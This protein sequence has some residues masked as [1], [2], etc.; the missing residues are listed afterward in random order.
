VS[1][2]RDPAAPSGAVELVLLA[3]PRGF[4]AGVE[5]AIKALA[6]M[7]RAFDA[8][9]YC[10]HEIVHNKLVV[11]RFEAQGVVFVNDISEVPLGRPIMLS[12]HGSAP[13][14]VA[15]ARARGSY[16]VDSVCPL[17]TKVHHEVKVRA[18]KGYR[19]VYVGH[20]GHEEAMGTMAVAPDAI[21]RVESVAE[22]EALPDF[23][24]PTALLAQT[25]LSHRDW[26]GVADAVR[27]RYPEVWSPGRS[28]LCF[29]TT[30][31]QS[32]L[33]AMAAR[34]D[35]IVVIGSANSSNTRALEKLAIEAGCSRVYRVNDAAE[36]PADLAGTVGV[37]AGAS[38]PEELVDAVIAR[39]APARG[40]ELVNVTDEDEYFPPP[41]NIRD[42]QAAIDVAATCMVGGSIADR[43][44][45]DDR[46]LD[47]SRVLAAL[48]D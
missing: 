19:I 22:V 35:A 42:L 31:R 27:T 17:V 40:V 37:T 1:T 39:L 41:R 2:H 5:M 8:P 23:D 13:E 46:A 18:G 47:A 4:C 26:A 25:T 29:A 7:V 14:V 36:L 9:V 20:E 6:W 11:E 45:L 16:V 48:A 38:A 33:T 12:A 44:Q 3:S 32:A 10:Y 21:S 30:N 24:Q 34:C 43:R 28:D 15:A